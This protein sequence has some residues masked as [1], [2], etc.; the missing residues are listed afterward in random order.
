VGTDN[1]MTWAITTL[2]RSGGDPTRPVGL[3]FL[4]ETPNH[5]AMAAAAAYG[6]TGRWGTPSQREIAMGQVAELLR[7]QAT[8]HYAWGEVNECLS[9]S[10]FNFWALA[11]GGLSWFA[12]EQRDRDTAAAAAE[13]WRG[14][15]SLLALVSAPSGRLRGRVVAPGQRSFYSPGT[16]SSGGSVTRDVAFSLVMNLPVNRK[17][18]AWFRSAIDT[19]HPALDRAG[20]WVVQQ[21]LRAHRDPLRAARAAALATLDGNLST[22]PPL[23]DTLHIVR[24]REGHVAWFEEMSG[25]GGQP[26]QYWGWCDY[27]RGLQEY[28]LQPTNE[29]PEPPGGWEDG[30]RIVVPGVGAPG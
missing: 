26:A 17:S 22:L 7:Q 25:R 29:P 18:D 27:G 23:R 13:W 2:M 5:R 6:W 3:G 10:H 30:W 8:G 20:A 24:T 28:G 15:M 9:S 4:G 19:S 12:L 21:L 1:D 14:E 16:P 11:F